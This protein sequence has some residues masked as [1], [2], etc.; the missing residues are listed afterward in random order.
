MSLYITEIYAVFFS[1]ERS[2]FNSSSFNKLF[3]I[4]IINNIIANVLYCFFL[5]NRLGTFITVV[6][7]S[8]FFCNVFIGFK[9]HR[10]RNMIS[11]KD[12]LEKVY[13]I[14]MIYVFATHVLSCSAQVSILHNFKMENNVPIDLTPC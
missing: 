5:S 11:P 8:Y 10:R 9:L 14:F 13:F 6:F 2:K 4:Y 3:V 1:F 7:I 12:Q